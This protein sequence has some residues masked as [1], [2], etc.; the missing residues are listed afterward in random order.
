MGVSKQITRLR[1]RRIVAQALKR[2]AFTVDDL[3]Q[4]CF[5]RTGRTVVLVPFPVAEVEDRPSGFLLRARNN[6]DYVFYDHRTGSSNDQNL[7]M[8]LGEAA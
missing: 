8:V 5:E 7:W 3:R 2:Q 4:F 6:V 1:A